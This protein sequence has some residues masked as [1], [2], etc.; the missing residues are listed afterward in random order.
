MKERKK[1]QLNLKTFSLE[2]TDRVKVFWY[3]ERG[4]GKQY[5][6]LLRRKPT[7]W[8]FDWAFIESDDPHI[9]YKIAV[10]RHFKVYAGLQVPAQRVVEDAREA[11]R[12]TAV[13][14]PYNR[15]ERTGD[16]SPQEFLKIVRDLFA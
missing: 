12:I 7:C 10:I 4:D 6:A 16:W 11:W 14:Y 2:L 5:F 3:A 13:E 9:F 15:F 1:R 8:Q